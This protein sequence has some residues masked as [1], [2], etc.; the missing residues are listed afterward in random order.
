MELGMLDL[1]V[2]LGREVLRLLEFVVV[3]EDVLKDHL[4]LENGEVLLLL[5]LQLIPVGA[6]LVVDGV[7]AVLG[8]G[9]ELVA[10]IPDRRSL[11]AP[12]AVLQ[13][14]IRL[15]LIE[16]Q[17]LFF[18]FF[19]VIFPSLLLIFG[20]VGDRLGLEDV[21]ELVRTLLLGG[22][23]VERP[24]GQSGDRNLAR[25]SRRVVHIVASLMTQISGRFL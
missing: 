25:R 9:G 11:A 15:G 21:V 18:E 6:L 16:D 7:D 8:E 12:V 4:L 17:F 14:T 5:L 2:E 19:G 1:V 22:L 10:G 3:E 20:G 23:P 13:A 24:L